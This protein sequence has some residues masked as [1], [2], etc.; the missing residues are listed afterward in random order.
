MEKRMP[1]KK[2]FKIFITLFVSLFFVTGVIAQE[3]SLPWITVDKWLVCGPFPSP[4]SMPEFYRD[5]LEEIGGEQGIEPIE[6]LTLFSKS[7]QT[8]NKQWYGE[9]DWQHY[10]TREDGYIDLGKLYTTKTGELA[11]PW[12]KIAYAFCAIESPKDQRVLIEVRTNDAL[13][14][15]VNHEE[16][17]YNRLF[18]GGWRSGGVDVLVIDLKKGSNPVLVKLGD[19]RYSGWGFAL[20]WKNIEDKLYP[21]NKDI[22]LPHFRIGEKLAGWAYISVINT[23][24]ERLDDAEIEVGEN[25]LFI[26]KTV[27]V[28]SLKPKWDSRAAFWLE[29]QKEVQAGDTARFEIVIR[30]KDEKHSLWLQPQV[31]NRE[32]YFT[33]TYFSEVDN[34]VQ[35]YSLL[36]PPTYDSKQPFPLLITLHGAHVKD[37]IGS[38]KIKDWC[39]IATAY[40]RGNTGYREIGT[41]DVFTVINEIKKRYNIDDNRIYLAGHSMGGHGSWYLGVHY[42]DYWAALNPMS[43]YGDYRLWQQNIPDWQAPLFEDKSANFF[44]ENLLHLP[45]YNIHGAKD[46]D[47]VVE[48]SRR[49]MDAL[50]KLGY[51]ATYDERPDKPHWWGMDFPEAMEFLQGQKRNPYP[52][53]VIFKTNRL[54]YNSS[55]WVSIDEIENIPGMAKI[56]AKI[57]EKN[58]ISVTVEN[59]LQ[60]SLLLNEH[61]L[62]TEKPLVIE[63]NGVKSFEGMLPSSGKVTLK[64]MADNPD[65]VRKYLPVTELTTELV[66]THDLCGPIIDAYSNRFIYIYGTSGTPKDTEVNRREAYQD[67]LDWRTW[68]NGNSIIKS[69]REVTPEDIEKFNLIL[70]GSPETNALIATMND[71][72]P[73]RIEKNGVKVGDLEYRGK[74]IGVKFIYPNPLNPRKYVLI[75]AGVTSKSVD[76]IHRLGDPLYDPLPDYIV[77]RKRDVNYDRHFFLKAGFFDRNWKIKTSSK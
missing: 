35:P 47:V 41:N 53:E 36:V 72:L 18:R 30:T 8:G 74:D 48:H 54:K 37:C 58:N 5:N 1:I 77:F 73:I 33:Q 67:A 76:K 62:N 38:Y 46:D 50:E 71:N 39:I 52:R 57:G 31:R 75:N 64:A 29:T 16:V 66:K 12:R 2:S 19:Y 51:E 9:V 56:H 13:Q 7:Y 17:I 65:E 60:Y 70:F 34:S 6:G 45:V 24:D 23:T 63:N 61:L 14:M 68:A 55:Y 49:L 28:P 25:E 42:P 22:L 27:K 40:G 3:V 32:E 21:N 20:R 69:D 10:Q 44:L 4:G 15:W 43:G 26:P 11:G 59:V